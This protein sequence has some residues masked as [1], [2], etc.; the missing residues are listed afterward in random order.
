MI[1]IIFAI[2]A[3]YWEVCFSCGNSTWTE[4]STIQGLIGRVILKLQ[5]SLIFE[6]YDTLG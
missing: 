2:N 4:C 5:A 3:A 1:I 6:L